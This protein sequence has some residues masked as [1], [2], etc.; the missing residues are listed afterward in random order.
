M[1]LGLSC[2]SQPWDSMESTLTAPCSEKKTKH[3]TSHQQS[4]PDR[5][6]RA[7]GTGSLTCLR[8]DRGEGLGVGGGMRGRVRFRGDLG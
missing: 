7:A 4:E 5:S 8:R 3:D 2:C 1:V 6:V